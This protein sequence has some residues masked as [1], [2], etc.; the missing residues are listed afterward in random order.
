MKH[1]I[2]EFVYLKG[3]DMNN[4]IGKKVIIIDNLEDHTDYV[5]QPLT[6]QSVEK[7][8]YITVSDGESV[9]VAGL[10]ETEFV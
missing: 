10:E 6:I 9:W 8:N 3:I 5:G 4:L 2:Y 1:Y 7:D